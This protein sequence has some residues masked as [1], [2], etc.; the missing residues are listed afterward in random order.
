M[1]APAPLT[2]AAIATPQG[3][4][5]ALPAELDL[6]LLPR[7]GVQALDWCVPLWPGL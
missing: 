4:P 3:I 1:A 7:A 2:R 5:F 6:P